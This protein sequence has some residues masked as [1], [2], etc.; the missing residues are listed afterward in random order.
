MRSARQTTLAAMG[1]IAALAGFEH[2]LG[3]LLQGPVAPA[4]LVIQSWPGSAFYRSLQGEPAL[5]VIPNLAISGIATM[6]LSGVF[7]VWVVRFADRPRS[8][9]VIAT[10]SVAL[11]L[12]GGGFGPPVLGLIL[13]IAAIKVTA[14]L[15]WWRQR[16]ASP[17]SRALAATWPFLLPACIAAWLMALV[18]V[19]ALD[20]FLGIESVAVTLTVL[21]L[22]FA[23]LPLSILSSFARDAHA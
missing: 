23:L 11:L 13:A 1:T 7:F 9:L 5:T 6:A 17:I 16:R 21:A 12:V 2:G 19:A 3:E 4:A 22:A 8:A 20:Y 14:P 18:G 10:L 15:T